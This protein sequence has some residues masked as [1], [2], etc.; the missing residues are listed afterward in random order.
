MT[1]IKTQRNMGKA[2][3]SKGT[4][5]QRKYIKTKDSVP[6]CLCASVPRYCASVSLCLIFVLSGLSCG[7]REELSQEAKGKKERV[8]KRVEFEISATRPF[9]YDSEGKRDP[10]V[11]LAG[12][13][14]GPKLAWLSLEGILWDPKF[15]MAIIN[16]K[17]IGK[18]DKIEGAEVIE[19]EKD[20][21]VLR[22]G[23]EQSILRLK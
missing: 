1:I 20:R 22:Y 8:R 9:V 2:Q 21:V 6:L 13:E 10:F 17:I 23:E 4:K 11:P 15:P 7:K 5:A 18:G 3:S 19:I 16:D 14:E 12:L